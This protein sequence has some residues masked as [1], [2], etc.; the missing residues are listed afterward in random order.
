MLRAGCAPRHRRR[1]CARAGTERAAAAPGADVRDDR[2][3]A[4]ET[5][6]D[7]YWSASREPQRSMTSRGYDPRQ[8]PG[9]G[10]KRV[11]SCEDSF[12]GTERV[13]RVGTWRSGTTPEH[14]RALRRSPKGGRPRYPSR[15]LRSAQEVIAAASFSEEAQLDQG[16]CLFAFSMERS[17]AR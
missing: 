1:V 13:G 12:H 16:S 15:H 14:P 8:S 9:P 3:L 6:N 11:V 5:S 2:L 4:L 10:Y 17:I 7:R